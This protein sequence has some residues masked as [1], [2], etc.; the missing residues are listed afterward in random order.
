MKILQ[1][2]LLLSRASLEETIHRHQRKELNT[3]LNKYQEAALTVDR[4]SN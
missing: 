3:R 2:N 4:K 1:K